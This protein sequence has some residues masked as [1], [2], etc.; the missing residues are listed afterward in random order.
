MNSLSL[1]LF[2]AQDA[3]D[4]FAL[5]LPND[6]AATWRA[7]TGFGSDFQPIWTLELQSANPADL[8]LIDWNS[9]LERAVEAYQLNDPVI[10][11]YAWPTSTSA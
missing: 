5:A 10:S 9:V 7:Q 1:Q 3:V 11:N 2:K 4:S 8:R 6:P